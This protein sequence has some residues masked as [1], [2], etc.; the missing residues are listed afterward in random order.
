MVFKI[1]NVD[2]LPLVAQG[3]FKWQRNDLESPK[4]GRTLDG[5]MHRGRVTTK[6]R[7]DITCIPLKAD[8]LNTLLNLIFP[9]YVSV[10]Y[11]DPM[12]GHVVKTMYSNNNPASCLMIHDDGTET[13]DSITFPLIEQ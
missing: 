13:W 2:V 12:Q 7:L 11:D 5:V 10:E 8:Q 4:A 3:G 6:I 9:E 1:N